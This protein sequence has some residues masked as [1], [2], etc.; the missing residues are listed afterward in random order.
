MKLIAKHQIENCDDGL[1]LWYA[2]SRC[3]PTGAPSPNGEYLLPVELI[4]AKVKELKSERESNLRWLMMKQLAR[5][6]F[7][8]SHGEGNH[9]A[10]TRGVL[11]GRN[12]N[13]SYD[14]VLCKFCGNFPGSPNNRD[15]C[16][17]LM[18]F[19]LED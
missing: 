1:C 18:N 6:E 4:P 13:I 9:I 16:P 11:N 12:Y 7:V 14:L 15:F 5:C 19:M 2:C 10:K 8:P 3:N 17:A